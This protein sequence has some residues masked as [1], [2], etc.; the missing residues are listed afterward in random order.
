MK[1]LAFS[2]FAFLTCVA[3]YPQEKN[4]EIPQEF[5]K[6]KDAAQDAPV[7]AT[8]RSATRLFSDRNDLTS[9]IMVIPKD[10]TVVVLGSVEPFLNVTFAGM[11]GYIYARHAEVHKPVAAAEPPLPS[12]SQR[13]SD[14]RDIPSTRPVQQRQKASRYEY[15]QH[16]YGAAL[17][18]ELY[19]GKIWK[20][21]T[22]QMIRDSWGS[23]IKINMVISGN[24]TREEWIYRNTWLYLRNGEL[25]EWGP[26]R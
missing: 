24:N 9:V 3:A 1:R 4:T 14:D 5:V 26:V 19:A 15:L 13:T 25:L 22:G 6:N 18:S 2:V 23:P 21:M 20:G 12:P 11:E 16:K 7:T 17:A 8:I 10:S